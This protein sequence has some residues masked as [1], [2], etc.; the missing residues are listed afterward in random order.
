MTGTVAL[1]Q[2]FAETKIP[3]T[4]WDGDARHH[5]V[6][7][8]ILMNSA[9]KLEDSGDGNRLGMTRTVLKKNGTDT[10]LT[11]PAASNE[12]IPVDNEFG[13]GHL[14]A[15]RALKQFRPGEMDPDGANVGIIGW[16]YHSTTGTGDEKRYE[17]GPA[18]RAGSY[19]S[20]TLTWD[21]IV[22]FDIDQGNDNIYQIGDT[23][24]TYPTGNLEEVMNDLDIYLVQ[25][26][27]EFFEALPGAGSI[28]EIAFGGY[29]LEH[30][31]YEIPTT[32][33]YDIIV[34]H[35]DTGLAFPL[36]AEEYAIAWWGATNAARTSGDFNGDGIVD[37]EDL[38]QWIF[39][40][41]QNSHSDA[42]GDGDS[43]GADFLKWQ[44]GYGTN[45]NALPAS[46]AV[47]EP[48]GWMLLVLGGIILSLRGPA[49]PRS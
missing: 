6:M 23:F 1:L 46:H 37:G 35:M 36:G 17:I 40:F 10:W 27:Q 21:R 18:L 42:D 31:F 32:G 4:N 28:G 11:S 13:A 39:D 47:P 48:A 3:S 30:V 44:L 38:I 34:E 12:A 41:G 19:I 9:D 25:R 15:R 20:I 16:D 2:E 7:K 33:L 43:D 5:E 26:G 29:N 8:A 14:N 22:E 49:H 45:A 24:E